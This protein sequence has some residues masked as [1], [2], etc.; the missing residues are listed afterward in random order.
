MQFITRDRQGGQKGFRKKR[1]REEEEEE[2]EEVE[3]MKYGTRT[4]SRVN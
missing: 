3:E 4:I 1:E 2:E